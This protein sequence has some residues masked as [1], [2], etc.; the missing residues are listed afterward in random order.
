MSEPAGDPGPTGRD[1]TDG[2]ADRTGGTTAPP[3]PVAPP[4]P[5]TGADRAVAPAVGKALELAL[6]L[7]Y[8]GLVTTALFGGVVP[9]YRTSAADGVADRTLA[10]AAQHV[11]GAVPPNATVV[12]ARE[13]VELP[14]RIRGR[15]Y[16][17]RVEDRTLVLDHPHPAVGARAPLALP[18]A[19]VAVS[20]RW[21]SGEPALVVVEGSSE[22]LAV[23]LERGGRP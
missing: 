1:R 16:E 5:P 21:A 17:V 19:V 11:Q 22:G 8:V 3:A 2:P 6:V 18:E 7:L 10:S 15:S 13:R 23:R 4:K 9:E 20:G 12:D 14:D